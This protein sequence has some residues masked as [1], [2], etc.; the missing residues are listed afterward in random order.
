MSFESP[1]HHVKVYIKDF[2]VYQGDS[3]R[4]DKMKQVVRVK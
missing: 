4:T 2:R 3:L 1:G